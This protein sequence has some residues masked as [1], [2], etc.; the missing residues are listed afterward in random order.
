MKPNVAVTNT[1]VNHAELIERMM[2]SAAMAQRMLDK[3][4]DS[5]GADCD[6]MESTVRMGNKAAIASAAHRH[7]GTART[8][9]TPRVEQLAAEI[10]KRAHTDP[11]SELLELVDQMRL[12]HQEVRDVAERGLADTSDQ[13]GGIEGP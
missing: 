4:V 7:K 5:A 11:T 10:E 9:A 1:A 8:M 6:L 2:G 13:T 12:L 3:F